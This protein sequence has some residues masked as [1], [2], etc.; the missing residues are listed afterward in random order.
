[1]TP[2]SLI[3]V[4]VVA[5]LATACSEDR[6][7]EAASL[8]AR[9]SVSA[10]AFE[11]LGLDALA[12]GLGPTPAVVVVEWAELW[13]EPPSA[14][15]RVELGLEPARDDHRHLRAEAVGARFEA[16]VRTWEGEIGNL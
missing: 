16:L 7:P 12:E 2:R 8:P 3:T 11:A 10:A 13:A 4:L 14:V 6:Q 9:G 15:L 5:S 1:M